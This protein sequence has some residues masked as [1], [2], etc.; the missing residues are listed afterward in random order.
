MT[1]AKDK[2]Y[3]VGLN[4]KYED[5]V[6]DANS[7]LSLDDKG[8]FNPYYVLGC[9]NYLKMLISCAY[10]HKNS[11]PLRKIVDDNPPQYES[12]PIEVNII[13]DFDFISKIE[14]SEQ[15]L[16]N[17]DEEKYK[18]LCETLEFKYRYKDLNK[19]FVKQSA[20]NLAH[21]EFSA[22]FDFTNEP[23]FVRHQ[24][25]SAAQK[26]TAMHKFMQY[27]DFEKAG[28]SVENEI[29]R[30]VKNGNI[31]NDEAK[32]LS[33]DSLKSFFN[34]SIGKEILKSKGVFREQSF[35]V[36]VPADAIYDDLGKEFENENIIIQGFADLCYFEKE[37]ICI[38]DYKTDRADESELV[39]R[40][41]TQLDIYGLALSQTFNKKVIKR[42]IFSFYLKKLI[43]L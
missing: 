18:K 23:V 30:L 6:V 36:E 2:L 41:K 34:S 42:A 27:C 3:L 24:K 5:I 28:Q 20:S 12:M 38:V 39:K 29:D 21:K 7:G 35:M 15:H 11:G 1:R 17:Y 31:T 40:Y 8:R 19:I 37:G 13:E 10:F 32:S 16:S 22:D 33:I 43:V 14:N 25:L 4:E 9:N 26:G